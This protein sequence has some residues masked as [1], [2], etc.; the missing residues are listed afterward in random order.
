MS[1]R[2]WKIFREDNAIQIFK[3]RK[4]NPI[5]NWKESTLLPQIKDNLK[6]I[7]YKIPTPI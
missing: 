3:G 5:R 7:G 6:K 4:I 2:D 1:D